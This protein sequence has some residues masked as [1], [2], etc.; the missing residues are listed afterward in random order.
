MR[1]PVAIA[2]AE[3]EQRARQQYS[4]DPPFEIM[5]NWR[6]RGVNGSAVE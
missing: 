5:R 4:A 6:P 1:M 3:H 2:N